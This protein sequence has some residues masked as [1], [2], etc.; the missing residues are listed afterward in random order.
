MIPVLFKI[1][2]LSIYSFGLMAA[3]AF[4]SSL[5]LMERAFAQFKINK[6]YAADIVL[7]AALGGI[8]GAKIN[9]LLE[10]PPET[11]IEIFSRLF[12]GSGLTWFG[13]FIGGALG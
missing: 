4:L 11:V 3:L 12:S 10:H 8:L 13:G 9:H 6:G 2:P 1:G 5:Y 7:A